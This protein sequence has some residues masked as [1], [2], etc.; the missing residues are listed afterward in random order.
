DRV[1]EELDPE[2]RARRAAGQPR[3]DGGRAAAGGDG[4]DLGRGLE[5]VAARKQA[6]P[7]PGVLEDRVAEERVAE[8]RETGARRLDPDAV[9]AVEGDRVARRR[10][11]AAERVVLRPVREEDAE[12]AV[13]D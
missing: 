1:R 2:T 13:R 12:P 7:Q 3:L 4:L 9:A 5:V 10:V 8:R 6:D 11:G